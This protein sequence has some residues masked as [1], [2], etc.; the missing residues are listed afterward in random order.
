MVK[1]GAGERMKDGSRRPLDVKPGDRVLFIRQ[2]DEKIRL[3]DR[4]YELVNE[5]QIFAILED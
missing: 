5:Y 2:A 1:V 3:D 4:D